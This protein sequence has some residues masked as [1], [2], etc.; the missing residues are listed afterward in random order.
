[1]PSTFSAF[2]LA[3]FFLSCV[4]QFGFL[5]TTE[6][7][8]STAARTTTISSLSG[9]SPSAELIVW[10]H[11]LL[12]TQLFNT[13]VFPYLGLYCYWYWFAN[14]SRGSAA[15]SPFCDVFN[16]TE[17]YCSA[18]EKVMLNFIWLATQSNPA[19]KVVEKRILRH[20]SK[21]NQV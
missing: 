19:T 4:V 15:F 12:S 6:I 5:E 21:P 8:V 18:G 14:A 17:L 9:S 2:C 13:A 7:W 3:F 1:M 10:I 16:K 20:F 11:V